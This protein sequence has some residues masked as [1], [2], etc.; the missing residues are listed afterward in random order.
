M[1]QIRKNWCGS[2]PWYRTKNLSLNLKENEIYDFNKRTQ[3]KTPEV[4]L[5]LLLGGK[6][7]NLDLD[8]C[9]FD[10]GNQFK[11]KLT[12]LK[13][14]KTNTLGSPLFFTVGKF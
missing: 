12:H 8:L 3:K 1:E 13:S 4:H 11:V 5:A 7:F 6:T 14:P 2:F 9:F 10:T